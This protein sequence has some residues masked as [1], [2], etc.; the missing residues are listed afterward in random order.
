MIPDLKG[1]FTFMLCLAAVAGWAVIEGAIFLLSHISIG[2]S[3]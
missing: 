3:W 2:W 1:A